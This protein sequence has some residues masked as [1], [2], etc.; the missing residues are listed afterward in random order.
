MSGKAKPGD[1]QQH[2]RVNGKEDHEL[3]AG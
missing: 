1:H 2:E 3:F